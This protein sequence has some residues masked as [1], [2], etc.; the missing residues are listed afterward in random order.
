MASDRETA[1][2]CRIGVLSDTHGYLDP[3]V[4]PLFEG[5]DLILHAGDIGDRAVLVGLSGI[6][7]VVAV[8]GNLDGGDWA[9]SLPTE[10]SGQVAGLRFVV[11][12]KRKRLMKRFV[13]GK[14]ADGETGHAPDLVV[15]G[16]EHVPSVSWVDTTLFLN[17][18]SA[19]SPY[20]EDETPTI[21]IVEAGENG[22]SV[23]FLPL[24][25]R[26]AVS[27]QPGESG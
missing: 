15:M 13:S 1:R 23:R 25:R 7:P 16:H 8:A 4:A 12:H 24:P 27:S 22:L 20:E 26:G 5:V 2:D 18:G 3:A 19:A 10:A 17:P 9:D 21:A 14:L 11:G 6:A